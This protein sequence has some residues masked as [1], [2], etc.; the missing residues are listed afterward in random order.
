MSGTK[1]SSRLAPVKKDNTVRYPTRFFTEKI[2]R[3]YPSKETNSS[4]TCDCVLRS[5][6]WK[7]MKH[8]QNAKSP[9]RKS[10][11]KC[12][13][14]KDN[15]KKG[16]KTNHSEK[17]VIVSKRS[18][19]VSV[20]KSC[21]LRKSV[22]VKKVSYSTSVVLSSDED[23]D[24][25]E[26]SEEEEKKEYSRKKKTVV[27]HTTS[28]VKSHVSRSNKTENKAAKKAKAI[29]ILY[30]KL[31]A[32]EKQK[33]RNSA[34]ELRPRFP[35][36][37]LNDWPTARTH[38]MASLNAL[39]KVH[40]LYENEGRNVGENLN[41]ADECSLIDFLNEN[42]DDE[43]DREVKSKEI[44]KEIKKE[45][46]PIVNANIKKNEKA[47]SNDKEKTKNIK[48]EKTPPPKNTQKGKRKLPDIE[49]ID[50]RICKRMASLNAQA[51]LAASYMQEPRPRKNPRKSGKNDGSTNLDKMK[52]DIVIKQ[53]IIDDETEEITLIET[54]QPKKNE[55]TELNLSKVLN[56][57]TDPSTSGRNK[58]SLLETSSQNNQSMESEISI[59]ERNREEN[60]PSSRKC[61][62]ENSVVTSATATKV[63]VTQYTEVTKVQ[64]NTHNDTEIVE[65]TKPERKIGEIL[66]NDDV[67]ITQMYH[68]QSNSANESYCV[69][70]QTTYKP[71]TRNLSPS[72]SRSSGDGILPYINES[73]LP[74]SQ[75]YYNRSILPHQAY[76]VN[77]TMGPVPPIVGMD[78]RLPHQFGGSAFTVPHYRHPQPMQFP[79]NDYGY[80]Q[81]AGPL[82]QP[83]QDQL[84]IHKPVPYH[85]Q[86]N[87]H[88]PPMRPQQPS[89]QREG[90]QSFESRQ[91]QQKPALPSHAVSSQQKPSTSTGPPNT[92][93]LQQSNPPSPKLTRRQPADDARS[94]SLSHTSNSTSFTQPSKHVRSPVMPTLYSSQ[95]NFRTYQTQKRVPSTFKN[96]HPHER[97]DNFSKQRSYDSSSFNNSTSNISNKISSLESHQSHSSVMQPKNN[98]ASHAGNHYKNNTDHLKESNY[99]FRHSQEAPNVYHSGATSSMNTSA[100]SS[101]ICNSGTSCNVYNSGTSSSAYNPSTSSRM[102][103]PSTSS[104]IVFP[105]SSSSVDLTNSSSNL[106][107]HNSSDMH[108]SSLYP[109]MCNTDPSPNVYNSLNVHPSN[110]S[111]NFLPYHHI[112]EKDV[113]RT[114]RP[115]I[116]DISEDNHRD[117]K[118]YIQLEVPK[119]SHREKIVVVD[120]ED[121]EIIEKKHIQL[122]ST[123]KIKSS[124]KYQKIESRKPEK[125]ENQKNLEPEKKLSLNTTDNIKQ[126]A[127]PSQDKV[128]PKEEIETVKKEKTEVTKTIKKEKETTKTVKKEKTPKEIM[129]IE[130]IPS[131]SKGISHIQEI[132]E[133]TK[134]ASPEVTISETKKKKESA[135]VRRAKINGKQR[136]YRDFYNRPLAQLSKTKKNEDALSKTKKNEDALSKTKKNEDALSKTKKNEDALSK[137]K[138]NEDA[139]SKTKKNEDALSKTKKNEDALSKT[140]KNEDALSKTKKNEDALSKTKK[141]E[142]AL[143]KTK[144]NE[145]ALSKTKKNEDALSKTKKNEDALSKTKKNED[146][147]SKT[148]KNEDA[149]SKTKK[150]EDVSTAPEKQLKTRNVSVSIPRLV[151][152]RLERPRLHG[153]SWEGTPRDKKVYVSLGK[154]AKET[155]EMLVRVYADLALFM[156]CVYE[157]FARFREGREDN[158]YSG[159]L[160]I[161]VSDENIEKVSC[162]V[163]KL[164]I[165]I[166]Q[167]HAT[168]IHIKRHSIQL[169]GGSAW[170]KEIALSTRERRSF[171]LRTEHEP[172]RGKDIFEAMLRVNTSSEN[173][174]T[175]VKESVLLGESSN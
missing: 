110:S 43:D 30:D 76:P 50:T 66:A 42:S 94:R 83:T 57:N 81:P 135:V 18:S 137:T 163:N 29:K 159:K 116:I 123:D 105:N 4:K 162:D 1:S 118:T 73:M 128:T 130:S 67:A 90:F 37:M 75:H 100:G 171:F 80:F 65:K 104:N 124:D 92:D 139:L 153:W 87:P 106:Q 150:N 145:D 126:N 99:G 78:R 147:L 5:D 138:K 21:N 96:Y 161:S 35:Y 98:S 168:V 71:G 13:M 51:I 156:K 70:M 141:N 72:M 144:K 143:S 68:Y 69:Q 26:E 2:K 120:V 3:S 165:Y 9:S 109:N 172:H 58:N 23:I 22:S 127:A 25:E 146:A 125:T 16:G 10:K 19:S 85:P 55:N 158:P 49:I 93:S 34:R 46:K 152:P 40:V 136:T 103:Q 174:V 166:N 101:S 84:T 160:A 169:N 140:K 52:C 54:Q 86:P 129:I 38:R 95:Q 173:C 132:N 133:K 17:V 62:I 88:Q 31:S 149:L 157:W 97:K 170:D 61:N 24:S 107:H 59:V 167:Y 64:I 41:D 8:V 7:G 102:C 164:N 112:A 131:T 175:V 11:S 115:P 60:T 108:H 113:H 15:R 134:A 117:T 142:D 119:N 114:M 122:R 12:C 91:S 27:K 39:A 36:A 121:D 148:K 79:P 28:K 111:S 63:G 44:K 154:T 89:S 47:K 48:K 45:T 20:V 6:S 56:E 14:T 77:P 33:G 32:P 53:E 74:G 155:Y 151:L 82:I